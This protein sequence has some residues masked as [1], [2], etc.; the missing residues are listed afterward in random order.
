MPNSGS[1]AWTAFADGFLSSTLA[2]DAQPAAHADEQGR[3]ESRAPGDDRRQHGFVQAH[4][5]QQQRDGDARR[6]TLPAS[7]E[8]SPAPARTA[9]AN[10]CCGVS[11]S[12]PIDAIH[13]RVQARMISRTVTSPPM[14]V[15]T[16]ILQPFRAE[17][18]RLQNTIRLHVP[19]VF[20]HV[21][22]AFAELGLAAG[23]GDR[24][25]PRNRQKAVGNHARATT[26][27][28]RAAAS[29]ERLVRVFPSE[30]RLEFIACKPLNLRAFSNRSCKQ[31]VNWGTTEGQHVHQ[32]AD[33]CRWQCRD[34]VSRVDRQPPRLPSSDR[35]RSPDAC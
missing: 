1:A 18:R 35:H 6:P 14:S 12:A 29:R 27:A 21:P 5:H 17:Y 24:N 7:I 33:R 9:I 28:A 30:R 31:A 25:H 4:R 13:A 10:A 20:F 32:K 8:R 11:R 22:T 16:A 19:R 26:Q 23:K 2:L 15:G 34:T 3:I